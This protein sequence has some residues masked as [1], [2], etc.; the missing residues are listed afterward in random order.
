MKQ[1]NPVNNHDTVQLGL[2]R[3]SPY[4]ITVIY[5]ETCGLDLSYL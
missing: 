1:L 5:V 2:N 4:D 3:E